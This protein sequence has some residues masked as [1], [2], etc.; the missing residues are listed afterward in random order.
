[1]RPETA[2]IPF[3]KAKLA[4]LA[5]P[6]NRPRVFY[7]SRKNPGLTLCVTAAGSKTFYFYRWYDGKPHQIPLGKFGEI[8]IEQAANRVKVLL[9]EIA[10]GK[11]PNRNADGNE[12]SRHSR[13]SST[14][15]FCT[16]RP[17]RD[18]RATGRTNANTTPS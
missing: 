8:S 18:P 14:I 3:T 17:T 13:T 9:A 2:T 16:P 5:A 12:R 10:D 1:M 7:H 4:E 15:G 11:D 6:Q